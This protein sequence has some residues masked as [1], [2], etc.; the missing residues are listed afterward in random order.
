MIRNV[1]RNLRF[2]GDF[3]A[4][5]IEGL[6]ENSKSLCLLEIPLFFQ[7]FSVTMIS[8]RVWYNNLF[9][10]CC[11]HC[12]FMHW[13]YKFTVFFSAWLW[14]YSL[15]RR[16]LAVSVLICMVCDQLADWMICVGINEPSFNCLSVFFITSY[17]GLH[18]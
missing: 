1:L 17:F 9:C 3:Q 14:V 10:I 5:E 8:V 4:L 11:Y 12:W 16:I 2:D 6:K 18:K 7:N 13:S 15:W